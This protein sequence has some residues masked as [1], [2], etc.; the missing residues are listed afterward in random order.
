[1]LI[2]R[3]QEFT[4]SDNVEKF[5]FAGLIALIIILVT[6]MLLTAI[7]A[8]VVF[9]IVLFF[10]KTYST[11]IGIYLINKGLCS[12]FDRLRW[13]P[14]V[15]G[16][17]VLTKKFKFTKNIF[18][19]KFRLNPIFFGF[20]IGTAL[21]A[22]GALPHYFL[23]PSYRTISPTENLLTTLSFFLLMS[24][25]VAFIEEIIFRNI[26]LK[27]FYT[28]FRP[29]LAISLSSMFFAFVHFKGNISINGNEYVTL[30][31]GFLCAYSYG[32]SWVTRFCA[33]EFLNLTLLGILLSLVT[34]KKRSICMAI[35]IHW[36][37]VFLLLTYKK[38]VHIFNS[39]QSFTFFGSAKIIDS[40]FAFLLLA[41]I[42]YYYYKTKTKSIAIIDHPS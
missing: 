25:K 27:I 17:V 35:G 1:M 9:N 16:F 4:I 39:N 33:I 41:I 3:Q 12:F 26:L 42:S 38:F 18:I 30:K 24:F 29:L 40:P 7:L 34:L 19:G 36:G 23:P 2:P 32:T 14:V 5:S 6:S 15:I 13:I 10:E 21:I 11:K 20:L 28:A 22:L 31:D 37:L 8:P